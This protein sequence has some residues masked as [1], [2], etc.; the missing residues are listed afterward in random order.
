MKNEILVL[1]TSNYPY[2]KGESYLDNEIGY[3]SAT[4]KKIIIISSD[5]DGPLTRSLPIN[6]IVERF[7]YKINTLDKIYSFKNIFNKILLKETN[8]TKTN[9]FFK[10]KVNLISLYRA[11][12]INHFI[13]HINKKHNIDQSKC[14]YYSYWMDD[15]AIALSISGFPKKI[16]RVHGWDLFF[17]RNSENYLPLRKHLLESI[18]VFS[19]SSIGKKYL[20]QKFKDKKYLFQ[21]KIKNDAVLVSRL[22]TKESKRNKL[23][24]KQFR[25]V[26]CSAVIPLKRV[27]LIID[28]LACLNSLNLEWV[29]FGDG[30]LFEEIKCYA[31]EKQINAVFKGNVINQEVLNYFQTISIDLFINLSTSEGIPVSIMEAFS[32][33]IPAIATNVGGTSEL[34]NNENGIL[35]KEHPTDIEVAKEIEIFYKLDKKNLEEKR[36]QAYLTWQKKFNAEK[37]YTEFTKLISNL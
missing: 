32:C 31:K 14:V 13:K 26:S 18:Q 36:D 37:N 20:F 24:A 23:D 5:I 9:S 7:N 2:G 12:K 8:F 27:R 11:D 22:G 16:C 25:I 19:I 4:F 35:L 33:G 10:L 28:S 21:N 3:L 17:E 34:V 29:H 6:T 15:S 30:P 1:L